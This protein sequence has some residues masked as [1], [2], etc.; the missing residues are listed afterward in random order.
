MNFS[1]YPHLQFRRKFWK[2][3]GAEIRI[4]TPAEEHLATIHQKA[5]KLKED[6]R[7]TSELVPGAPLLAIRARQVIDFGATYDIFL[8]ESPTPSFSLQR[9]GLQSNFVRDYWKVLDANGTQVGSIRETSGSLAVMRRWLGIIPFVG[10]IIDLVFAFIPQTY[11]IYM[12]EDNLDTPADAIITHRKNPVLVRMDLDISAAPSG[13]D[14][15]LGVAATA[16]LSVID[17][18]KN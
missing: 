5:F 17:A 13:Y 14:Y 16:L 2:L 4:F 7:L 8:A 9:K 18:V 10:P 15:N 11:G 3:F 1:Q 6:I 12:G